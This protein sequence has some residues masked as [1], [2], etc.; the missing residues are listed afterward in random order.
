VSDEAVDRMIADAKETGISLLGG[1]DGLIGQL[2]ARIIERALGAE[3]DGHLGY[4]KGGPAGRET[5]NSRNGHYGKTLTTQAG[6]VQIP[7]HTA[8]GIMPGGR[9]CPTYWWG[10]PG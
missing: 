10:S 9:G 1:R 2:T 7:G 5:G 4:E 8:T 3:L 6:L